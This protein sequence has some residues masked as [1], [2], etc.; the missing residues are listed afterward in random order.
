[1]NP[2]WGLDSGSAVHGGSRKLPVTAQVGAINNPYNELS[3]E[4]G[5]R[6]KER[7]FSSFGPKTV[8]EDDET[9]EVA[10]ISSWK[11]SAQEV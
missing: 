11:R 3:P 4:R 8:L 1:M 6:S 5:G 9:T 2:I 10:T 7:H